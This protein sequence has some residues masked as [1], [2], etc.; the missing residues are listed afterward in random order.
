M[1]D[2]LSTRVS[3][4][5]PS[6]PFCGLEES[7]DHLFFEYNFSAQVWNSILVHTGKDGPSSLNWNQVI[8]WSHAL[9]RKSRRYLLAK[10][11]LHACI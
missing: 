5:A 3:S 8:E 9:K 11:A 10:L 2:R 7:R 1:L 4:I 6:C